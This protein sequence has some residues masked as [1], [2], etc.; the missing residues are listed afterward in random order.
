M[1]TL[2]QTTSQIQDILNQ[3]VNVKTFGAKGD[4]IADDTVAIKN[5]IDEAKNSGARC[6]FPTGIY[7]VTSGYTQSVDYNNVYMEGS[8]SARETSTQTGTIILLDSTD[9][10]SFFYSATASH[11]L[12]VESIQFQCK[13]FV[14]DRSFFKFS[15][16]GMSLNFANIDFEEVERPFVFQVGC[17]FQMSCFT[18]IQF[19]KSG[20]FHSESSEIK[21]TLMILDNVHHEETVPVNTELIVCNL[22]GIRMIRANNF[23]IEGSLP[24]AGWTVLHLNNAW[25]SGWTRFPMAQ[26]TNFYSIWTGDYAPTYVVNQITGSVEFTGFNNIPTGS[27]YKISSQGIVKI[28]D[29]S[30]TGTVYKPSDVFEIEDYSSLVIFNGL[31]V[32]DIDLSEKGMLYRDVQPSASGE[33][34]TI[35]STLISNDMSTVLFRWGGGFIDGSDGVITPIGN[36]TYTLSADA[37]YGRKLIITPDGN[38]IGVI[39]SALM[40]STIRQYD[41]INVAMLFKLPVFSAGLIQ[42]W[43]MEDATETFNLANYNTDYSGQLVYASFPFRVTGNPSSIGVR[44]S[45]SEAIIDSGNLEIYSI[46]L[47]S[48]NSVPRF[49]YPRYPKNIQ[50]HNPAAPTSGEWVAGDI[51]YNSEPL[52]GGYVGWICITAGTPGTWKGFGLIES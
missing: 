36:T 8:S 5:A 4:G 50:T 24:S 46:A 48:G 21:G 13:Q 18:D 2:T 31:R 41:Q 26:I 49:E 32:R 39:I 29:A 10:D 12:K 14:Q 11:R 43:S 9:P 51:C 52:A 30:F 37:T 1:G 42:L 7:R 3:Y 28:S 40:K 15:A 33:T 44:L 47:Y 22:Q 19:R 38:N 25:D 35:G 17:Y 45:H 16:S 23:L 20:M 6:F 27:K 34:E